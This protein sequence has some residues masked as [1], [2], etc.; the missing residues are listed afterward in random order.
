MKSLPKSEYPLV[1]R[2]EFSNPSAWAKICKA[3][4]KPYGKLGAS[5]TFVDDPAFDGMTT[6]ECL[7]LRSE[8]YLHSFVILVDRTTFELPDRPLLIV[9]LYEQPGSKFRA[10]P[11]EIRGI[12][13]NLS[14]ANMDFYEFADNVD[15][16]GVFRGFPTPWFIRLL[17]KLMGQDF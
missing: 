2:T 7:S 9:D 14:L 12:E 6:E 15:Q 1:I 4:R 10:I 11:A 5:L 3:V 16:D 17:M 13:T 8:G